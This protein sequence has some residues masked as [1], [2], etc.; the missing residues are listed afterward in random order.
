MPGK[1]HYRFSF[2]LKADSVAVAVSVA[3]RANCVHKKAE[4]NLSRQLRPT[5][6]ERCQNCADA[7]AGA[8]HS[9]DG[10]PLR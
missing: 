2:F 9:A 1:L 3:T 10:E 5:L 4:E 7:D 6:L 8:L